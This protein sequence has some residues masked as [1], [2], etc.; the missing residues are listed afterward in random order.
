MA[1]I[2]KKGQMKY[3]ECMCIIQGWKFS[4]LSLTSENY[5]E[6]S[7]F[8]IHFTWFYARFKFSEKV[9]V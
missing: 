8:R 3:Y 5:I 2:L 4:Y 6:K 7:I 1:K 9:F